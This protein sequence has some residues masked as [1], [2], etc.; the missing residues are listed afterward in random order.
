MAL[1]QVVGFLN[2]TNYR[3]GDWTN[4]EPNLS[5]YIWILIEKDKQSK[6]S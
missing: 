1:G 5:K 3:S 6:Q 4:I 2:E